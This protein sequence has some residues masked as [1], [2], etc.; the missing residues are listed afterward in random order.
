MMR[1][2][3]GECGGVGGVHGLVH[4]RHAAGGGGW[5]RPCSRTNETTLPGDLSGTN[6]TEELQMSG[7]IKLTVLIGFDEPY[8][9]Q[10]AH[11]AAIDALY[12]AGVYLTDDLGIE[13]LA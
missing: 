1:G 2:R 10:D 7:R 11:K 12:D 8:T 4:V 6:E 13:V 5:N 3:C 9:P